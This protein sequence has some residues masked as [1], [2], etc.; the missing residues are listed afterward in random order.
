MSRAILF[1]HNWQRQLERS[2]AIKQDFVKLDRHMKLVD[3]FT[4][5]N[6]LHL[7]AVDNDLN[8]GGPR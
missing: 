2:D 5:S 7:D 6:H 4:P 3:S 8:F 1:F